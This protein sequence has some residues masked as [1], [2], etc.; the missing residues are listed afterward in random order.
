MHLSI[1]YYFVKCTTPTYWDLD[2]GALL[3]SDSLTLLLE[4]SVA[5]FLVDRRTLL[6]HHSLT[7]LLVHS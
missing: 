3:F 7:L 6:I 2:G 5:S 4:H 1:W